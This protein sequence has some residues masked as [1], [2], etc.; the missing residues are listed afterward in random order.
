M[1]APR[2]E[3]R[4]GGHAERRYEASDA[5]ARPLGIFAAFLSALVVFSMLAMWGL[6]AWMDGRLEAR[7]VEPHPMAQERELPPEPRLQGLSFEGEDTRGQVQ[8]E[9][10]RAQEEELLGSY[11]WIDRENEVVRI[12]IERAMELIAEGRLKEEEPR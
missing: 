9:A 12:P 2:T 6:F 8:L 10:L 5:Q 3:P 11:A 4:A 7:D 1:S